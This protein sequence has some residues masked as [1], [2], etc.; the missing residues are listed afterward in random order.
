MYQ[1]HEPAIKEQ[2]IFKA[3]LAGEPEQRLA[4]LRKHIGHP[5]YP[6]LGAHRDALNHHVVKT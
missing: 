4:F 3:L 2:R 5:Q 1:R 6:A